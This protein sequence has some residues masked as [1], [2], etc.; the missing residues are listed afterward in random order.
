MYI[1]VSLCTKKW[2]NLLQTKIEQ[3]LVLNMLTLIYRTVIDL[4]NY[5]LMFIIK[6]E[7]RNNNTSS[8]NPR[9]NTGVT[10]SALGLWHEG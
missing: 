8:T 1:W 10:G 2:E 5:N 4:L 7:R 3:N 6:C 9:R